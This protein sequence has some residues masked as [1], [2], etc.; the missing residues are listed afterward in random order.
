MDSKRRVVLALAFFASA[1]ALTFPPWVVPDVDWHRLVQTTEFRF[2]LDAP[3][4]RRSHPRFSPSINVTG[5]FIEFGIIWAIA[6]TFYTLAPNR[7]AR[8]TSAVD[9]EPESLQTT[10]QPRNDKKGNKHRW[11]F[12]SLVLLALQIVLALFIAWQA[13]GM[14]SPIIIMLLDQ[15][16]ILTFTPAPGLWLWVVIKFTLVF[17]GGISF[18]ALT[19]LRRRFRHRDGPKLTGAG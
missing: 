2:F 18:Y 5:L 15:S 6:G 9:Q 17:V 4:P 11:I 1:L 19:K 10:P 13:F 8:P 12:T 14:L 7:S 3:T 16:P